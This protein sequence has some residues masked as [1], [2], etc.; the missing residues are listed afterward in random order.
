MFDAGQARMTDPLPSHEA[1]F[2]QRGGVERAIVEYMGFRRDVMDWRSPIEA[3]LI[4]TQIVG[5]LRCAPGSV[6]TAISRL[7]NVGVLEVAD[8]D[9]VSERGRRCSRYRLA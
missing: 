8:H 9:G 6:V 5:A 7:V 1:A 3:D 2:A 4:A